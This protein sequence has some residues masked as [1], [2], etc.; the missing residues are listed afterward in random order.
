MIVHDYLILCPEGKPVQCEKIR[1]PVFCVG[2]WA[3]A[4]LYF[5]EN[6]PFKKDRRPG[7]NFFLTWSNT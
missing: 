5:H 6:M 2:G 4:N 1:C 3:S 7:G